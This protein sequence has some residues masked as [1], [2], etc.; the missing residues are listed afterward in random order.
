MFNIVS[1]EI[2]NFKSYKGIHN[3]ELPK[4]P[5]LYYLTGRNEDNPRLGAN[6][7]GKSTLLDAIYWCLYGRTTRGLKAAEVVTWGEKGC[8]VTVCLPHYNIKRTQNPNSL[9]MITAIGE[10]NVAQEELNKFI[11]L[12][13]DQFLYA[14]MLP[15]FGQS[16]FDLAPAA[17][18]ALFSQIM[19]LDFWLEKS[20]EASANVSDFEAEKQQCENRI[21]KMNGILETID[22]DIERLREKETEFEDNQKDL[23]KG[24]EWDVK[25][26]ESELNNLGTEKRVAT[27]ALTAAEDKLANWSQRKAKKCPTCKQPIPTP[28]DDRA[29]ASIKQNVREWE[30]QVSSLTY[31]I[32]TAQDK[33]AT[34]GRSVA[35]EK[36][37]T[38]TYAALIKE[39][40]QTEA[41]AHTK[42]VEL[43]KQLDTINEKQAAVQFWIGGFKRLRLFLIEE[44][45][46]QLEVEVNNNLASLGLTDHEISFD[47]E[48][49]NKSGGVT[50]G[51]VV[52]IKAPGHDEP[53]RWEAW[54]G[55]VTQRLRLAGDLGLA[56]LIMERAGLRG[57]IEFYDEPS[58]HMS[59]EGLL[60]LCETLRDRAVSTGK[61]I[62]VVDHHAT[63][64]GDFKQVLVAVKDS[65]GSRLEY[66]E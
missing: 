63:D 50:K 19:E 61:C 17:K 44:T 1:V 62:F 52:L 45:L 10:K 65:D 53:V 14:V 27:I 28:E 7:V 59:D 21:S 8:S 35:T 66:L 58:E 30:N 48:R 56:N 46:R 22:L 25:R 5:G 4:E 32:E 47:V 6:D 9:T 11:R 31:K 43:K 64:F 12:T 51:F 39:K 18:L 26:T 36:K 60:D 54:G 37:R 33:I 24:F 2:E 38:N 34:W 49:E 3:F 23:I 15:Q 57:E 29:F 16:F 40:R 55:G 13:P 41:T 42:K 20:Q